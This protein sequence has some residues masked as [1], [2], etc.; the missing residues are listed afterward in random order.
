[1]RML[2]PVM[3]CL[4]RRP[5]ALDALSTAT[6]QM[7]I[8]ALLLLLCLLQVYCFFFQKEQVHVEHLLFNMVLLKGR[9]SDF[10]TL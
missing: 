10:S 8:I 3:T 6:I 9:L 2:R 7:A 4:N 5:S 1:M